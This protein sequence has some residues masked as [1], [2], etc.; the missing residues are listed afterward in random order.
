MLHPPE[1]FAT[2]QW[3][4]VLAAGRTGEAA[5]ERALA[6]L[7]QTYWYPLYAY[8]RRQGRDV[9]AAQDLTQEFFARL[10][11]R[12]LLAVAEPQR[13]RFRAF[14]LTALKHFLI[15]E[16]DKEHAQKRGGGRVP[17]ALDFDSGESRYSREPA[18][19]LTPEKLYERQW[20]LAM[21]DQVLARLRSEF[22]AAGKE[23][24]FELLKPFIADAGNADAYAAIAEQL[25]S[26]A[27]AVKVA[28]HRLRKRYRELLR[29][30]VAQTVAE[31]GEIDGEIR[32]LFETL[33]D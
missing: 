20:T 14:L 11:D 23:Q 25:A 10:L 13:G 17:L 8:V 31:P 33:A 19:L 9:H 6:A 29:A 3:S 12:N 30:E 27:A 16:W 4:I 21:L 26:T 1:D 28:A 22:A 5:A 18:H 32:R 24:E 2:T 7:C 15:N